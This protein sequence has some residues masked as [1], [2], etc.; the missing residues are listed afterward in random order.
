MIGRLCW[1][2]QVVGWLVE[3]AWGQWATLARSRQWVDLISWLVQVI[4][5]LYVLLIY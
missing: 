5:T 2:I 1:L 4:N 3:G